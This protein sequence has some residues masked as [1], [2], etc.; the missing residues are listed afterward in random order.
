MCEAAPEKIKIIDISK[1]TKSAGSENREEINGT[2]IRW[3]PVE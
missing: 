1:I 3:L 2:N